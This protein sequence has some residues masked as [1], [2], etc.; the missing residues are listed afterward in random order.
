MFEK[1]RFTWKKVTWRV[2]KNQI[3]FLSP[4]NEMM[5]WCKY[6]THLHLTPPFLT[7]W[8][9]TSFPTQMVVIYFLQPSVPIIIGLVVGK[10]IRNTEKVEANE[11]W[12]KLSRF[13]FL[14]LFFGSGEM[15]QPFIHYNL[16]NHLYFSITLDLRIWR[17]KKVGMIETVV[18]VTIA[19]CHSTSQCWCCCWHKQPFTSQIFH[20]HDV[21]FALR[22]THTHTL[23]SSFKELKWM[24]EN[25]K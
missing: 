7:E 8:P 10:R 4:F 5:I 20:V 18:K 12:H 14:D 3:E 24:N 13:L 15:R 25:G 2:K 1:R 16:L 21:N 11:M 19:K 9:M 22:T 23:L 17:M 6:P